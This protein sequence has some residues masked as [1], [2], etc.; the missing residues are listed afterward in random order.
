MVDSEPPQNKVQSSLGPFGR[1]TYL[2]S[3]W[4]FLGLGVLGVFLPLLPTTIFIILAAWAF[5][6]SSPQRE[7]WLLNH[8]TFGPPLRNWRQYRAISSRGKRM[9][10]ALIF[11]SGLISGWMLYERP[12]LLTMVLVCLSA[13]SIYVSRIPLL[14]K[15]VESES[16]TI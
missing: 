14:P 6:R 16:S 7:A 2:L 8:K 9:A 3:A 11:I 13:V 5:A 15:S 4:V 12:L 10:L 1:M